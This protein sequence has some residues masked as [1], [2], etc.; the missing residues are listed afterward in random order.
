QLPLVVALADALAFPLLV[1]LDSVPRGQLSAQYEAADSSDNSVHEKVLLALERSS[2]RSIVDPNNDS[3]I[4]TSASAMTARRN[5]AEWLD[6]RRLKS[7]ISPTNATK[8]HEGERDAGWNSVGGDRRRG[9]RASV[10]HG[11]PADGD[12]QGGDHR[13]ERHGGRPLF[14]P[15]G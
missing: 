2:G 12:H 4:G 5:G 1:V 10:V 3:A 8:D 15:A 11:M 9:A 6:R 14:R 13:G 7:Y